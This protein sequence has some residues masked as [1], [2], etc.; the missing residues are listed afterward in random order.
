M[1][2]REERILLE[3]GRVI[4]G[5]AGIL[6]SRVL[7]L[8]ETGAKT[9]VVLDAAMNDLIRPSLYKA[10]H[11]IL[12]VQRRSGAALVADVVGPVCESGDCFAKARSLEPLQ[13]GDLVAVMSAGAYGFSM[14]STY[15][16]RP[17]AAEVMVSGEAFEVVRARGSV[18][19]LMAGER[20]PVFL[21]DKPAPIGSKG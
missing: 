18:E 2:G 11:E 3:P 17:L 12:P 21:E 1:A 13:A 14:A 5:N 10:H 19:A 20:V 16:S 8:K 9:F 7:Y 6:L 4:V 15:N